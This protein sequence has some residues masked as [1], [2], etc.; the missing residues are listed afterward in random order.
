MQWSRKKRDIHVIGSANHALLLKRYS[1]FAG[2]RF[3]Y[4]NSKWE[5]GRRTPSGGYQQ[6]EKTTRWRSS[7]TSSAVTSANVMYPSKDE[8]KGLVEGKPL[9]GCT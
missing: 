9:I 4:T 7:S 8:T 2:K 6:Y 5:D 3:E 1:C